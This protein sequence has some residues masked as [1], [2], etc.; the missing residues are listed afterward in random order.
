MAF[1]QS[2]GPLRLMLATVALGIIVLAPGGDVQETR[3]G[4]ALV[5]TVLVP[6]LSPMVLMVLLLDALM[7]RVWMS[8]QEEAQRKRFRNIIRLNLGLSALLVV[9][10]SPYFISL[11]R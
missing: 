6:A 4:M 8:E 5:S 10:M 3:T 1:L 9:A 11:A 2:I 7:S